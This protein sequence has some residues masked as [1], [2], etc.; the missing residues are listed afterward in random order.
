MGKIEMLMQ[1]YIIKSHSSEGKKSVC[2]LQVVKHKLAVPRNKVRIVS[3]ET[4]FFSGMYFY[5][6]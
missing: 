6:M 2:E 3:Q 1:N 5:K 4:T